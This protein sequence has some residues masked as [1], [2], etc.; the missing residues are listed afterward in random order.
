MRADICWEF[1]LRNSTIQTVCKNRTKITSVFER[2]G[3][4]IKSFRKPKGSNVNEALLK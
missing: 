4:S 3:S 1:G 2:N